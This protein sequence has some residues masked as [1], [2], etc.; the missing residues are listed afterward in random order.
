MVAPCKQFWHLHELIPFILN[1]SSVIWQRILEGNSS[2]ICSQ[3]WT[4]GIPL[5][6][7]SDGPLSVKRR[8]FQNGKPF[9]YLRVPLNT[10]F[11]VQYF[12]KTLQFVSLTVENSTR[13][14]AYLCRS[15]PHNKE[16]RSSGLIW[17]PRLPAQHNRLTVN[18][19]YEV[20]HKFRTA[21]QDRIF[22][23]T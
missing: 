8:P 15:L 7:D 19:E 17:Y 3:V 5:H 12:S 9:R 22:S 6:S 13:H 18:P 2:N 21:G 11:A 4:S 1:S 14:K 20:R 16:R 23:E 10:Y